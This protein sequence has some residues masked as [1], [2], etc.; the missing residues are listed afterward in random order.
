MTHAV[1]SWR[2]IMKK[3]I[4]I[5]AILFILNILLIGCQHRLT[6]T[7][8]VTTESTTTTTQETT[9]TEPTEEFKSIDDVIN[10]PLGDLYKVRATVV[11]TTPTGVLIYDETG[12]IYINLGSNPSVSVND[13]IEV[14]GRTISYNDTVEFNEDTIISVLGINE[15]YT[16]LAR[17]LRNQDVDNYLNNFRVGDF[18]RITGNINVNGKLVSLSIPSSNVML[19]LLSNDI[20]FSNYNNTE[21]TVDGFALFVNGSSTKYLNILVTE[22]IP[23]E[24]TPE[25]LPLTILSINDLHG[26]VERSINSNGHYSGISRMSYLVN[27]IRNENPLDDV[28]LIA[29][30]DMFQGTAISNLTYGESVIKAMNMMG[31]DMMGIGNHEFDWGL[32][33]ILKYFDNDESNGEANFPLINSNIYYKNSKQLVTVENGKVFDSYIISREGIN[34]GIMSYIG[35]LYSS[36]QKDKLENYYFDLDFR[37]SIKNIGNKLKKQGADIIILNIH[38]Y[39]RY[40]YNDLAFIRDDNGDYLLDVIIAGHTHQ[41]ISVGDSI[42][43]IQAYYYGTAMGRIDLKIDTNTKDIVEYNVNIINTSEAG[44]NYD[45]DIEALIREYVEELELE[46]TLVY[47]GETVRNKDDMF[48]WI[49]NVLLKAVDADIAISNTG[50]VRGNGNI[51]INEPV[52]IKNV[53]EVYPFDNEIYI[54]TA[55]YRDIKNLLKNNNIFYSTKEGVTFKDNEYYRIAVISY[56]YYWDSLD[57][58][59]NDTNI[60]TDLILLH[61]LIEDLEIKGT[62]GEIFKPIS[63]PYASIDVKYH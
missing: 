58:L 36:I 39:D 13:Y 20:D 14:Y 11:G 17:E 55:K 47:A 23:R 46:K 41:G 6:T 2:I 32:E 53:F 37:N 19:T 12:F 5:L 45:E 25:Y 33:T 1:T 51:K 62:N 40:I 48:E 3:K 38:D 57:H 35:N 18:L 34:V 27:K 52:T 15:P 56:V 26:Y 16:F 43:L 59:R 4:V 61:L 24:V 9:I 60:K 42:P 50:G 30:G 21:V 28:V 31:F 29:N 22:V 10:S 49:G 8:N 44:N 7:T 63:N 54:I